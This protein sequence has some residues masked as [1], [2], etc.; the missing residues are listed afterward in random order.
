MTIE[1]NH[2]YN[3][4]CLIGMRQMQQQGIKADWCITDPPYGIGEKFKGG[5]TAKMQFNGCLAWDKKPSKEYFDIIQQVSND[6]IIWGGNYFEHLPPCRG[7]IVWD[8]LVSENF[9]LAMCEYAYVSK[10]GLAKIYKCCSE[11]TDRIHETQKPLRLIEWCINNYT[12]EGDLILDPFMGSFT[13]A[14]ACHKLGRHYIGFEINPEYYKKGMARLA[15]A[16]AQVSI[17]DLI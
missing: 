14:V 12:R 2:V 17:F 9:S 16:K 4:D 3:M 5:K 7:F 15:A 10:D 13:T 8:K 11:K 1:R 6:Q